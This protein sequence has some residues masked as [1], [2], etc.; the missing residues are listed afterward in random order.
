MW[1]KS[2]LLAGSLALCAGA[3]TAAEAGAAGARQ[4]LIQPGHVTPAR[5]VEPRL[6]LRDAEAILQ[7]R[8]GG[9]LNDAHLQ[10][11][12]HPYYVI[13]WEM[14]NGDFRDFVVDALTG[15]VR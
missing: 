4:M 2:L 11:G 12:E 15:E 6:L 14:P 7:R 10:P 3:A 1:L 8:F 9:R 5:D 13:R